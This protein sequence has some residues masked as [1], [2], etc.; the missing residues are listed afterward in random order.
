MSDK[1]II[2]ASKASFMKTSN[3]HSILDFFCYL[4][5]Y[6]ITVSPVND[7]LTTHRC[8]CHA[9]WRRISLA[10]SPDRQHQSTSWMCWTEFA[11]ALDAQISNTYKLFFIKFL[12]LYIHS[13]TVW[14]RKIDFRTEMRQKIG[15]KWVFHTS[16]S[17]GEDRN[18]I[19]Q[20]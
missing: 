15:G 10:I 19:H 1:N 14:G 11:V 13:E 16:F 2:L 9:Y 7:W 4:P 3:T 6:H 20:D 12:S 17:W 8:K 18:R 5:W